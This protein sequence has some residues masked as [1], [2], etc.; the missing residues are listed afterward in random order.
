ML[1]RILRNIRKYRMR[2]ASD[3]LPHCGEPGH[4]QA[5]PRRLFSSSL[6]PTSIVSPTMLVIS[7]TP[8]YKLNSDILLD[9]FAINGN[10]F[11]NDKRALH[12]TRGA[13]QVCRQ[14]RTLMLNTS[15][16]W[17]KLLDS[18]ELY[19]ISGYEWWN[20]LLRRSEDAPLWI[21]VRSFF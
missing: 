19:C 5:T 1:C 4:D 21:R 18:E 12:N 17:A 6:S 3:R 14:W 11:T 10:I 15:S 13:S 16:I 9:I 20:E 8:V 7:S 2:V